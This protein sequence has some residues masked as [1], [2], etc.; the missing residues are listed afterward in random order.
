MEDTRAYREYAKRRLK[1]AEDAIA[2]GP[3]RAAAINKCGIGMARY[4]MQKHLDP[5]SHSDTLGGA[6]RVTFDTATQRLAEYT[7]WL[8][9]Q[10]NP[11]RNYSQLAKDMRSVGWTRVSRKWVSKVLHGW[12]WSCRDIKWRSPLKYTAANIEH[13]INF[14]WEIRILASQDF[15]RVK[16]LDE[17]HFSPRGECKFCVCVSFCTDRLAAKARCWASWSTTSNA[18]FISQQRK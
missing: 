4:N 17:V 15:T 16:Y 8:E 11:A 10:I 7:L 1:I 3:K 2:F 18:C 5:E 12:R 6:R 9:L 14:L 13:Y